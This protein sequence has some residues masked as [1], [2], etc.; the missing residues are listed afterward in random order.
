MAYFSATDDAAQRGGTVAADIVCAVLLLAFS[1]LLFGILGGV[2]AFILLESALTRRELQPD[3]GRIY[4]RRASAVSPDQRREVIETLKTL[5]LSQLDSRDGPFAVLPLD[6]NPKPMHFVKPN[7]CYCPGLSITE[8]YRLADK[9][10][11]SLLELAEDRRGTVAWGSHR[12]PGVLRGAQV[13]G[14]FAIMDHQS[15]LWLFAL[16]VEHFC[17]DLISWSRSTAS[18]WARPPRTSRC[19]SHSP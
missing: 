8:D 18:S 7:L 10:T 2:I 16:Q 15:K 13:R 19:S 5:A 12:S 9:F 1:I 17:A 6:R 3:G 4:D 14:A 11:L